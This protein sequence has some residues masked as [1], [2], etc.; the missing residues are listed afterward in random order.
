VSTDSPGEVNY[1]HLPSKSRSSNRAPVSCPIAIAAALLIRST[2]SAQQ[3]GHYVAGD[4]GLENVTAPPPGGY[5]TYLPYVNRVD[6]IQGPHGNTVL[7][8][9]P[10]VVGT[11]SR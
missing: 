3:V 5:A 7:H 6:S 8:L 11:C 10:N 9:D 1:D 4:T 2:L